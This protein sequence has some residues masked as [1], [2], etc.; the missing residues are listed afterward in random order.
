MK[1]KL[2]TILALSLT[3]LLSCEKD[4]SSKSIESILTNDNKRTWELIKIENVE[5]RTDCYIGDLYT[6][7]S[8]SNLIINNNNTV[9]A[10]EIDVVDGEIYYHTYCKNT[11]IIDTLNWHIQYDT[12]FLSSGWNLVIIKCTDNELIINFGDLGIVNQINHFTPVN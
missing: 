8:D 3:L 10:S 6:F 9:L 11:L 1:H 12:L 5:I 4:K 7:C 2:R